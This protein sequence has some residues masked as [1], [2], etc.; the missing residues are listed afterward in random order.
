M[1]NVLKY[2]GSKW[3]TADWIISLFPADYENMTYLEPFFGSGAVF[4]TK[5]RTLIETINDLDYQVYNYFK[6]IRDNPEE[7]A[8]AIAFTPWCRKEYQ[9]S[10][11]LTGDQLEDARRFAV[12]AW[13][14]IGFKSSDR[15]G[16]RNNIK[17]NNGNITQF[18][19]YLP[20]MIIE[21]SGRL[22]H[23]GK[24]Q[25]NIEN[26]DAM[27]LIKRHAQKNVFIYADPPYVMSTRSNRIYKHELTDQ[28]HIQLLQVLNQHPGAVMIS[29]YD[30]DLYREMLA[31]WNREE[32]LAV[33]EGGKKRMEI[34]WFNYDSPAKQMEIKIG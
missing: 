25:V 29:G 16:W 17:S 30:C 33:A 13:Q 9:D 15:T 24:Y 8:K 11:E 27:K 19:N 23:C 31:G 20:N 18:H 32:Q 22:K 4:F 12:R 21:T 6:V 1:K 3:T 34:L 28:D 5:R 14:A 10:F 26:Q 2:P 7:L